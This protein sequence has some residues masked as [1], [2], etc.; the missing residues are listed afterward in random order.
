[1]PMK[2][3]TQKE[4]ERMEVAIPSEATGVEPSRARK[5]VSARDV[6]GSAMAVPS[7]GSVMARIVRPGFWVNRRLWFFFKRRSG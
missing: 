2:F 1:M 6:S 3:R 7:T 5:Q 4:P